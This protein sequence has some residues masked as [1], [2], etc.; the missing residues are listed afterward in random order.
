MFNIG[1]F[2]VYGR[3]GICEV[4]DI[5][6]MKMTGVPKDKLYYILMPCKDKSGK[7]FTPVEN[8]KVVIRPVITKE[9]AMELL[10]QISEIPEL[11]I[12]NEKMR[13]NMYKECIRSCECVELI[14]I[15]K[16]LYIRKRDRIAQGKKI[17]ATDERYLKMAEGS[18][19]SELSMALGIPENEMET[20]ITEYIE[21]Q[22][23]I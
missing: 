21:E 7:I 13:E 8:G 22:K 9:E 10:S 23:R 19:Y 14:K 20:Y 1:D 18:L 5:T 15:I 4:T 16:T 6:T 12:P 3:T 2:V 11:W 17:T